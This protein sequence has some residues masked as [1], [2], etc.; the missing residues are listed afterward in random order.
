ME[1][2][3]S[4]AKPVAKSH[5]C[6]WSTDRERYACKE[7]QVPRLTAPPLTKELPFLT[8]EHNKAWQRQGGLDRVKEIRTI[9][10]IPGPNHFTVV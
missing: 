10:D 4:W 7:G 3:V 6:L 8:V 2:G 9:P 5:R 1:T